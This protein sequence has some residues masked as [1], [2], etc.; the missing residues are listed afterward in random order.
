MK[1]QQQQP[2][3]LYNDGYYLGLLAIAPEGLT[4]VIRCRCWKSAKNRCG[5]TACTCRK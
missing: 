4:K 2:T 1:K 5:T 3:C